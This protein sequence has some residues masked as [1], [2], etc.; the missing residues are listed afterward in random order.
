MPRVKKSTEQP[1]APAPVQQAP[2]QE[3]PVKKTGVRFS[4]LSEEHKLKLAEHKEASKHF[5]S[6]LRSN[7]MLGKSYEIA[8]EHAK[9]YDAIVKSRT[10]QSK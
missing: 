7:L 9:K 4:K 8:L 1:A 2:V 5:K 6:S 10:E 3:A